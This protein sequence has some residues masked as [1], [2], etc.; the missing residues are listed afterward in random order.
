[1]SS[2]LPASNKRQ[3]EASILVRFLAHLGLSLVLLVSK[4]VW[5]VVVVVPVQYIVYLVCGA[6][7]RFM[8][9]SDRVAIARFAGTQ[10]HAHQIEKKE[11]QPKGW[12]NV[13]ISKRPG[14]DDQRTRGTAL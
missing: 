10:L 11:T 4:L 5:F 7:I 2:L 9:S 12:E 3:P 13:S 8:L 6:P 14:L 1:L